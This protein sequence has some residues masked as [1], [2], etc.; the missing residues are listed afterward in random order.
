M[1]TN[2]WLFTAALFL[3]LIAAIFLIFFA[4]KTGIQTEDARRIDELEEAGEDSDPSSAT[5]KTPVE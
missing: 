5:P 3:F 2:W 4:L 1:L